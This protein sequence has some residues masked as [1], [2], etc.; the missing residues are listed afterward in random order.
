MQ[1]INR[2]IDHL[3]T[4]AK[5]AKVNISAKKVVAGIAVTST[6]SAAATTT[7]IS[8]LKIMSIILGSGIVIT[9]TVLL[10][11]AS[12]YVDQNEPIVHFNEP[13]KNE[14]QVIPKSENEVAEKTFVYSEVSLLQEVP[15]PEEI[16]EVIAPTWKETKEVIEVPEIEE[17]RLMP[18]DVK[19]SEDFHSVIVNIDCDVELFLGKKCGTEVLQSELEDVIEFTISGGVLTVGIK[20][21]KEK[22]FNKIAK[23]QTVEVELTMKNL[24]SIQVQGSADVHSDDNIPSENLEIAV[25]G[26]GDIALSKITP[27]SY[28]VVLAGSGDVSIKG[29]GSASKGDVVITGSGDVCIPNVET[30][31]VTVKISGSGD[32]NVNA[33]SNLEV[34]I[35]GS[36]DVSYSGDP[37][38]SIKI[39]GSG[40]V[41]KGCE[42]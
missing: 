10:M 26:S 29:D 27:N 20:E 18:Q 7:L 25:R 41:H 42:K 37:E 11:N 31:K 39:S 36:G 1:E 13:Q 9:S 21:G 24:Q 8:K 17:K 34:S 15:E 38:T 6:L 2:N 3:F 33:K 32:V 5:T 14:I 35:A 22:E 28:S 40:E 23:H 30:D 16:V 12:P 19:D 4:K